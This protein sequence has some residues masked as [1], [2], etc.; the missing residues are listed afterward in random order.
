[1]PDGVPVAP[2]R[3][4]VRDRPQTASDPVVRIHIGRV[5]VRAVMAAPPRP[6]PRDRRQR[7][8]TLDEYVLKRERGSS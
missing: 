5:D 6:A 1:M 4:A 8:T 2:P 3:I 7:L